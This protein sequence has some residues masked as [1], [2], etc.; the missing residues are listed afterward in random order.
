MTGDDLRIAVSDTEDMEDLGRRLGAVLVG[1]DAVC[2][3]G[4]LGAGKTTL[5]RGMA[6]GLGVT[7]QV[8]S[9]TFVIAR[10]SRGS[11]ADLLHCDVYRLTSPEE[12]DDLGIEPAGAVMVVEWGE[13]IMPMVS[14]SWLDVMIDRSSG[15]GDEARQVSIGRVGAGWHDQRWSQ[16]LAV[17]ESVPGS[18]VVG[19]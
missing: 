10:R 12:F 4:P 8:S 11:R 3:S 18:G 14:D 6:V 1:G 15:L 17:I 13:S 2:L 9:P 16:V 5:T 7:D 19:R